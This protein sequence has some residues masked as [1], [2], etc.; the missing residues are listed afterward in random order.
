MV[1]T[2]LPVG[3]SVFLLGLSKPNRAQFS[4]FVFH[5]IRNTAI[6]PSILTLQRAFR[7]SVARKALHATGGRVGEGRWAMPAMS[8]SSAVAG[9]RNIDGGKKV[10]PPIRPSAKIGQL[11]PGFAGW[12]EGSEQPLI[13]ISFC[14]QFE[15]APC[16]RLP[17]REGALRDWPQFNLTR[18]AMEVIDGR[19]HVFLSPLEPKYVNPISMILCSMDPWL[20]LEYRPEAFEYYLLHSD[21]ALSRY[22]VMISG[23]VAGVLSLRFPWLFGP[24]IELMALFDGFQRRGVG[25]RI[26]DWVC[27]RY[28]SANLWATVS[29][30]NIEAQKFYSS[31]GFEQTAVLADLI[32]AGSNEI[33]LR[34]R[35]SSLILQK[36]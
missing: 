8:L 26:I 15:E 22:T 35:I 28:K 1:S 19:Q 14:G 11:I 20:T 24:F 12:R 4:L 16:C 30:F 21:P 9:G 18:N 36:G 3:L 7:E 2:F 23:N 29:S 13:S 6:I 34:K 5:S 27:L 33:L 31:A 32:K 10:C 17:G 25:S